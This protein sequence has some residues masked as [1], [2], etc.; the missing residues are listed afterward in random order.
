M[1]RVC[2][3]TD[4]FTSSQSSAYNKDIRADHF[5]LLFISL[6]FRRIKNSQSFNYHLYADISQMYISSLIS[7]LSCNPYFLTI[8]QTL[9]P[10]YSALISFS[11]YQKKP[12]YT[13]WIFQWRERGQGQK[14]NRNRQICKFDE[15]YKTIN[16]RSFKNPKHKNIEKDHTKVHGNR[17]SEK[18]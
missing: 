11:V 17:I 14:N 6:S 18:P 15:N 1:M 5:C 8:C 4:V 7:L 13:Y 12:I 16:L 9:Q 3:I 10:E 2:V